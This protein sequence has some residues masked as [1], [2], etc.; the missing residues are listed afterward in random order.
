MIFTYVG[1]LVHDDIAHLLEV[2]HE[3]TLPMHELTEHLQHAH[4]GFDLLV[5]AKK[6][7][8]WGRSGRADE[9]RTPGSSRA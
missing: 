8:V 3:I 4:A 7:P 2:P 1:L 5:A 9:T 6:R